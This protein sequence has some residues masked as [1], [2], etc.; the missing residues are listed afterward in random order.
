MIPDV[1]FFF[2]VDLKLNLQIDLKHKR[3]INS[4]KKSLHFIK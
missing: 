4:L 1:S 3:L 2:F